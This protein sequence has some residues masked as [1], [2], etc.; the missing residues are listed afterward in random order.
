MEKLAQTIWTKFY[1]LLCE[2][3]SILIVVPSLSLLVLS[4]CNTCE[5]L[6]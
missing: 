6:K 4:S 1:V 5:N 3:F 2:G